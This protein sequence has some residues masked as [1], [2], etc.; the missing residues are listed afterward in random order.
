MCQGKVSKERGKKI[1]FFYFNVFKANSY[2]LEKLAR[3]RPGPQIT[4]PVY[5]RSKKLKVKYRLR[6]NVPS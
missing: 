5:K 3:K 4:L 1:F 2:C 6:A